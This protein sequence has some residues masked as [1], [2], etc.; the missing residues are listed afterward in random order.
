MPHNNILS[1]RFSDT[2][3]SGS[4]GGGD[5][6]LSY[7]AAGGEY[8]FQ[9]DRLI[10]AT[11]KLVFRD[12][13]IYT[14]IETADTFSG[15]KEFKFDSST[16]TITFPP[17]PFPAMNG[18]EVA[19]ATY[20]SSSGTVS[21]TEPL[22][23]NQAKAWMKV[24]VDDDDDLITELISEA[25]GVCEDI[26][27]LSFVE[28]TVTAELRNDLGGVCLPY[29]P[30]TAITSMYD[31]DAVEIT[32][33]N[34]TIQGDLNKRILNP[35][36]CYLKVIYTAGYYVL[37]KQLKTALKMQLTWMYTHRGDDIVS[38]VAPDAMSILKRYTSW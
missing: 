15:Y 33:D 7:T 30:V 25:R 8:S 36:S 9:D 19:I 11:I 12:G 20:V 26:T 35:V 21:I 38:E 31:S 23:L 17:D 5:S 10:D 37:P 27:G 3:L 28:R 1:V 18:F 34:Y 6:V 29:G 22:T 32:S 14:P 2:Q 13:L 24:T 4:G 16:G